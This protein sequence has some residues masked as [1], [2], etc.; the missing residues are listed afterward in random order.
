MLIYLQIFPPCV[1]GERF[2]KVVVLHPTVRATDCLAVVGKEVEPLVGMD[3]QLVA[4]GAL[5]QNRI[6]C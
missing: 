6:Y 1:G 5:E 3:H 2:G 4:G